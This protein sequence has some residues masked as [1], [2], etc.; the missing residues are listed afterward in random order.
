MAQQV[1]H[2]KD[3]SGVEYTLGLYHGEESGNLM[4]YLN[5]AIMIIDFKIRQSK[6]YHFYIGREF[7]HLRIQKISEQY[8]YSLTVDTETDTPYN[9]SIRKQ[10]REEQNLMMMGMGIVIILLI[11]F[12][13]YRN[14]F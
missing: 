2:M 5:N 12:F 6:D 8:E 9:L 14:I 11:L 1:W 13:L 7:M 3:I 4:V 10:A